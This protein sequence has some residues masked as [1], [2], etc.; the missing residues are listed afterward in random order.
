MSACDA[1]TEAFSTAAG[2]LDAHLDRVL[3]WRDAPDLW[4][5]FDRSTSALWS[6]PWVVKD[7]AHGDVPI[8]RFAE[9][10]RA[11]SFAEAMV[12]R[13]DGAS[14]DLASFEEVAL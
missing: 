10:G 1:L 8:G 14:I 3:A 9:H 12:S 7:G 2:E 4:L 11:R 6:T 5:D 13:V